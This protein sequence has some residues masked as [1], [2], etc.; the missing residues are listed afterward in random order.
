MNGG[1]IA[2]SNLSGAIF[3]STVQNLS[4]GGAATTLN[5]TGAGSATFNIGN[6]TGSTGINITSG[7]SPQTFTS[8]NNTGVNTAGSFVF[9]DS[10]LTSGDFIYATTSAVTSGN[11]IK[12]GEGGNQNFSGNAILADLGN[13]GSGGNGFTGNFV[14][15][16]NAGVSKYSIDSGGNVTTVGNAA[17]NGGS[18]TTTATTANV[19]TGASTLLNIGPSGSAGTISFS[20]GSGDTGCTLDGTTGNFTC[21][22]TLVSLATSGTQGWWQLLSKVIS[23]ANTSYDLAIGGSATGSAF[24]VFGSEN[25][26][27]GVAKILSTVTTT[28]DVLSAS[29]S[30]IT[31]GNLLKLGE[32]GNQTFSGNGILMDFDNTGNGGNGF[33]GNAVQ[34]LMQLI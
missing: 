21:T 18:L 19:F 32:G 30:A 31:T 29:S 4:I 22:G 33:T 7:T 13:S 6:S 10:A 15:Y 11:I 25:P 20:G 9:N 5:L 17:I 3:N 14:L 27:S 28:G 16:K 12:I 8:S 23:P 26:T 24:Q 34:A 1:T 2:S